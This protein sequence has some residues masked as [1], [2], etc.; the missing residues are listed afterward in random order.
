MDPEPE[1][2]LPLDLDIDDIDTET[3]HHSSRKNKAWVS[4]HERKMASRPR[5]FGCTFRR[6]VLWHECVSE[7]IFVSIYVFFFFTGRSFLGAYSYVYF[8]HGGVLIN[9]FNLCLPR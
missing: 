4:A 5:W 6:D 8:M 3:Y 9:E 1:F 7:V 2:E